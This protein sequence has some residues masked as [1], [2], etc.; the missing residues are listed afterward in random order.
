ML[1][2]L[3]VISIVMSFE[4]LLKNQFFSEIA[5]RMMSDLMISVRKSL[6]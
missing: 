6:L 4:K 2:L 1:L 5:G 3:A